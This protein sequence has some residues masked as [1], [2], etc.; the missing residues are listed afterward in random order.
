MTNNRTGNDTRRILMFVVLPPDTLL[1][2]VA[3][4]MEV[5]RRA[6]LEQSAVQF[7]YAYVGAGGRTGDVHRPDGLRPTAPARAFAGR[8]L[9]SSSPVA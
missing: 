3:G 4:P 6:N 9:G 7:D 8:C 2:D 5:F 1:L